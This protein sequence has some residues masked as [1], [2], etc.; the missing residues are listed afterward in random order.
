M[1][2]VAAAVIA[3]VV[4]RVLDDGLG[5]P[6]PAFWQLA[7]TA[8]LGSDVER[9][10]VVVR[11]RGCSSR[12]T[13]EGRIEIDVTYGPDAVGIDVGVRPFGGDQTCPSNPATDYVVELDEPLGDRCIEGE[14]P[15]PE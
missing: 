4:M 2:L 13:A 1:A 14:R 6:E 9:I 8:E 11:A 5:S 3:F 10:P 12:R 7:P 15:L